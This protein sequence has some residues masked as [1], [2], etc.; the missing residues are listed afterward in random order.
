MTITLFFVNKVCVCDQ[1]KESCIYFYVFENG[2]TIAITYDLGENGAVSV[3]GT[4]IANDE[5][6]VD[7]ADQLEGLMKD[8]L[9]YGEC[10]VTE[11]EMK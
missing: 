8:T 6:S 2:K 7:S 1:L 4:F 10:K 5:F 11:V 9:G 3:T